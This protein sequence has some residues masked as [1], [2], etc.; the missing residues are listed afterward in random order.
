MKYTS[1]IEK[2]LRKYGY[3]INYSF[4][5]MECSNELQRN[6]GNKKYKEYIKSVDQYVNNNPGAYGV[7]QHIRDFFK[8][9]QK[10]LKI[11]ISG[12]IAI[13]VSMLEVIMDYI[14]QEIS[15]SSVN[16]ILELGGGDGWAADYIL[17]K[18][19][20]EINIDVVDKNYDLKNKNSQVNIIQRDYLDFEAKNKYDIVYSI[21]GIEFERATT[22]IECINRT[23][24]SGSLV[25]IGLRAQPINYKKFQD[26]MKMSG[27][28]PFAKEIVRVY[29]NLDLGPE[30]LPL[31]IFKK[32]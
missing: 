8:D 31:F 23:T 29:V 14:S 24:N 19:G 32:M 6:L 21:L 15:S 12:T 3:N 28:I 26:N 11:I 10:G 16:Q 5:D 7:E 1:G 13:S 4:D 30:T 17:S 27:F 18:L 20:L 2:H 22:L 9:N 25:L